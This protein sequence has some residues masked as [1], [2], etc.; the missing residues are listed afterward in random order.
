ME[1]VEGLMDNF[2]GYIIGVIWRWT[3]GWCH[4]ISCTLATFFNFMISST[5]VYDNTRL[6]VVIQHV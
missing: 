4:R 1:V 3:Y 6:V 5:K 2:G